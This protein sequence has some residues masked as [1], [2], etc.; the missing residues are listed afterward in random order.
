MKIDDELVTDRWCGRPPLLSDS[1]LVCL[2]VAQAL[3]QVHNEARRLRFV[4]QR[5]AT[6]FPY[7]PKRPGYNKRLRAALPLVKRVTRQRTNQSWPVF[8][9]A[10]ASA[11][12][13][14]RSLPH[15]HGLPAAL[16]RAVLCRTDPSDNG[17]QTNSPVPNRPSPG[18]TLA[19]VD[20]ID[21]AALSTNIRR[22]HRVTQ[23]LA[24]TRPG[25]RPRQAR[26]Q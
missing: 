25:Y 10:Q 23:I 5:L 1:E 3:L 18:T 13:G 19:F 16:V 11:I 7:R 26:C 2:A 9:K 24:P 14:H 8:H 12:V 22:S 15:R 6:L 21:S 17:H 4:G 20:A